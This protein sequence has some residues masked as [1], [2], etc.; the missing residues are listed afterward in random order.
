MPV[1]MQ[2]S[3]NRIM[4]ERRPSSRSVARAIV[5]AMVVGH[6]AVAG[7]QPAVAVSSRVEVTSSLTRLSVD[8]TAPVPARAFVLSDPDRVV[9]DLPEVNFQIDASVGRAGQLS[10]PAKPLP[11]AAPS[12]GKGRQ[13]RGHNAAIAANPV[14]LS[15]IRAYRF[16]MLGPGRSRIVI[17]LTGPARIIR[18]LAEP[19]AQGSP[20]RLVV[21]LA[22]TDRDAFVAEAELAAKLQAPLQASDPPVPLAAASGRPVI[23]ID[24][25]HGGIDAG[26]SGLSGSVEKNLVYDFSLALAAKLEAAGS[27]EV[28]LTRKGDTFVSL[29]DRVKIARDR[30]ASLFVSIHADTLSESA[31]VQGATIYTV[32]ENASDQEAGRIAEKENQADSAAGVDGRE[33]ASGVSDILFDLTRRETRAYSHLFARTLVG[34]WQAAGRLNK[35]PQRSAGFKVLK[36]PDVPSVLIELG[37]LS[38]EQDVA[39]LNSAE[40][41]DKASSTIAQSIGQFFLGRVASLPGGGAA[42]VA[43]GQVHA[44]AVVAPALH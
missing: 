24:P 9:I 44:G 8:L 41:R 2:S 7:A 22:S 36:A 38:S 16:G 14:G 12:L 3:R 27:Y 29:G 20:A 34:V 35:N 33:E 17:D 28:I 40:W 25:G 32:S 39:A 10:A 43:S 42:P 1:E 21:E 11:A 23:V 26:A 4:L 37:Y 18:A 15:L 6:A 30:Q 5:V 19:I 13:G 31:K